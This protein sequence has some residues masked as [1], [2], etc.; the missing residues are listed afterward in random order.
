MADTGS[1]VGKYG[2]KWQLALAVGLPVAVGVGYWYLN[3]K[4]KKRKVKESDRKI[5]GKLRD[6]VIDTDKSAKRAGEPIA[7]VCHVIL[8]SK[9]FSKLDMQLVFSNILYTFEKLLYR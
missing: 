1:P 2:N 4:N 5:V 6:T 3:N 7:K 9:I 8:I